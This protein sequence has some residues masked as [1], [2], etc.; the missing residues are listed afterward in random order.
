MDVAV[1][2]KILEDK[3]TQFLDFFLSKHCRAF[4]FWN[5][6]KVER[7]ASDQARR[8]IHES[9]IVPFQLSDIQLRILD[10]FEER[11]LKEL[12]FRQRVMKC[13]RAKVSTIYLAILYHIARFWENKKFLVFAD[14]LE[15]S[16]KLRRILD[17]FY[18][19]DELILKPEIGRKTLAEGLYLHPQGIPKEASDKDSFI[20]L[21]SGEQKNSGVGGS[22]DGL[23]W[24]EA[25]ISPDA[26]T[27][28]QTI[29][30]SLQGAL[31]DIAESTPS[32][33]GQDSVIFPEFE[34]PSE[35]CD[36]I[37]ISWTDVAEYRMDDPEKKQGFEAHADHNLY[38]KE[39]DIMTEYNPSVE[40]MLWR[41]YKLDELKNLTSFKQVFP[42]SK[43]E[44]F[45]ASAGLFFHGSLI[46]LTKPANKSSREGRLHSFS[47]QG[48]GYISMIPDDSGSWKVYEAQTVEKNYLI[49]VDI[50]E[51]KC[52]DKDGRDPDFS[53]AMVWKL[54]TPV[55]EVAMLR[56]HIPP[57][58]LA[59]QVSVAAR[60]YNNAM[61][62]PERNGPG[63]AFLVRLLQLYSNIARQQ[64]LQTGSFVTTT[65]YGFL[66]TTPSKV[67][68]LSCLLQQ[69]REAQRGMKIYSDIVR[70]EM[71][72]FTQN[73]SK[74]G[75]M[76]GY[77]DDTI[78]AMWL[79]AA[80]IFQTPSCLVERDLLKEF[81][82][83]NG[84]GMQLNRVDMSHRDH[85]VYE[86]A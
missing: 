78:S 30:P 43:E 9:P 1:Q 7:E 25:A 65:D 2:G 3:G 66:S 31:F 86:E 85:L 48:G 79:A 16:R 26:E 38:G 81:A 42:I 50:A 28:W 21:G 76:S 24:S 61:V 53:V 29:S 58:V 41:R 49:S 70:L 82:G 36:T 45:F 6:L 62:M 17:I 46:E 39:T 80:Y 23:L 20:L 68:A 14:R 57:E 52:A 22:L 37:F 69:I 56:E 54:G 60:Y 10:K 12:K 27:H 77:H 33:T 83:Q 8:N 44:A 51:G 64:R 35:N 40:Q 5:F 19:S 72:K 4:F 32:L 47:D 84:Q 18:Q 15:T 75:A 74:F 34:K 11:M 63:L 55:M 73:G 67:F 13:R 71:A 59:E